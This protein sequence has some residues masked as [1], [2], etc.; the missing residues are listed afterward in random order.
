MSHV[1]SRLSLEQRQSRHRDD[2]AASSTL[3]YSHYYWDP[4]ISLDMIFPLDISPFHHRHRTTS[5]STKG[6]IVN[7]YK[8]D[9]GGSVTVSSMPVWVTASFQIFALKAAGE[10]VLGG[11]RNCLGGGNVREGNM[12]EEKCPTIQ[13]LTSP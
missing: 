2:K 8:I 12:L 4:D 9:S 3:S 10:D 6:S 7:L 1:A 5:Y 13:L 11:K